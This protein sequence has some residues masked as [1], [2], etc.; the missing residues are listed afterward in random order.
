MMNLSSKEKR[1]PLPQITAA[2]IT[3]SVILET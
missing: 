2:A 1:Q 3:E